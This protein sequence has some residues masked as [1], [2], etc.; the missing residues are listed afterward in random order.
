[1]HRYPQSFSNHPQEN[2]QDHHVF[3]ELHYDVRQCDAAA[4]NEPTPFYV[5]R[6]IDLILCMQ[7]IA[8]PTNARTVP[9]CNEMPSWQ[10]SPGG[11]QFLGCTRSYVTFKVRLWIGFQDSQCLYRI[12]GCISISQ[13]I[14]YV[15]VRNVEK[16]HS[17]V[18]RGPQGHI[19]GRGGGASTSATWE[20]CAK[21]STMS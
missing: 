10:P 19:L 20:D 6:G 21:I 12:R 5:T 16:L 1:M 17:L 13:R 3:Q 11:S 14:I 8:C 15:P 7:C 4:A 2:L 9:R 18:L